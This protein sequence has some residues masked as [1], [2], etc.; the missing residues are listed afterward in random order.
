MRSWLALLLA[1]AMPL[2]WSQNLS[3]PNKLPPAAAAACEDCGVVTSIRTVTKQEPQVE[4]NKGKPSGL[5]AS[6]PLGAG[7]GKPQVGSSTKIGRDVPSVTQ[8][9]E[10][11]V[12]LDD[13]RYRVVVLDSQ[14]DVAKGDRVKVEEGRLVDLK[15]KTGP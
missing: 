13:G 2:A 1:I 12:R 15:I 3:D 11:I 6:I 5:V 4:Q 8:S 14:P 7:G 9:W 10:V